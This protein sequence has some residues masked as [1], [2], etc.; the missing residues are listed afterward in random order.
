MVKFHKC[1]YC[2]WHEVCGMRGDS[3]VAL[4]TRPHSKTLPCLGCP[5]LGGNVLSRTY[6]AS[7]LVTRHWH[8]RE[9]LLMMT[10]DWPTGVSLCVLAALCPLVNMCQCSPPWCL[11]YYVTTLYVLC[12][13]FVCTMSSICV[14]YYLTCHKWWA[15]LMLSWLKWLILVLLL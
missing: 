10:L 14:Y 4:C 12:H 2:W 3:A 1:T 7:N 15:T 6:Q 9:L 11:V 5:L 8:S 13:H